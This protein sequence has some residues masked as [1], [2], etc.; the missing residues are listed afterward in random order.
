[1][2][3]HRNVDLAVIAATADSI[4]WGLLR[5][6]QAWGSYNRR[7][8]SPSA[9][10]RGYVQLP[11]GSRLHGPHGH[12]EDW[13][14]GRTREI[15]GHRYVAMALPPPRTPLLSQADGSRV[16]NA[17]RVPGRGRPDDTELQGRVPSSPLDS[18]SAHNGYPWGA[19]SGTQN[20]FH[21]PT[22]RGRQFL[23]VL[24]VATSNLAYRERTCHPTPSPGQAAL[25]PYLLPCLLLPFIRSGD[26]WLRR[27]DGCRICGHRSL[28][29]RPVQQPRAPSLAEVVSA[30]FATPGT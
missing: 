6:H 17:R 3:P 25:Y 30:F 19:S 24:E 9:T 23:A 18:R 5:K 27:S 1:V 2:R 22:A 26:D 15:T 11:P 14:T 12:S 28:S 7:S 21:S 13:V 29:L 20:I 8:L 10:T 4:S 16:R